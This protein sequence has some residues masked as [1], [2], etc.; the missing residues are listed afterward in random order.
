MINKLTV[1]YIANNNNLPLK[2][3]QSYNFCF[4]QWQGKRKVPYPVHAISPQVKLIRGLQKQ[5]KFRFY[6]L[7]TL[8][9]LAPKANYPLNK[10]GLSFGL[11]NTS[12]TILDIDHCIQQK[13][14]VY[15]LSP[16]VQEILDSL[17]EYYVEFSPSKTGLHVFIM[18]N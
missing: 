9:I 3:K 12:F 1:R 10:L 14:N 11:H 4:W 7:G 8:A 6:N 18:T 16:Y 15:V 13:N 17:E 2:I 5:K